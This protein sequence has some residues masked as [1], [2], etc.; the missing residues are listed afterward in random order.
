MLTPTLVSRLCRG[1]LATLLLSASV[2]HA[3]PLPNG[4]RPVSITAREQPI[5]AF[6]QN[7]F[8]A[9]DVPVVLG[10]GLSGSVNGSFSGPADKV[11]RDVARVYSLVTY[12]DGAVMHVVPASELQR[13]SFSASPAAA[14]RLLREAGEQGLPDAR[15]TLR[16]GGEG[17]LMAV[18]T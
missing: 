15:N 10:Q 14:E 7:L 13:K 17:Q 8:A 5:G 3:G 6:L 4:Q 11:L 16:R 1:A 9:V 12:F 2:A 18:G